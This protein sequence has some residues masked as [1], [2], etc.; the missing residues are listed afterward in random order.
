M[1]AKILILV[2]QH[3]ARN[4]LIAATHFRR[5][6]R[7]FLQPMAV[8]ASGLERKA[9]EIVGLNL[10]P[11]NYLDDAEIKALRAAFGPKLALCAW[12]L[13]RV[14][15]L[16][17]T[18]N[19]CALAYALQNNHVDFV[20]TTGVQAVLETIWRGQHRANVEYNVEQAK[21]THT[22]QS[23][24][25]YT[26]QSAI[27]PFIT[28]KP[29]WRFY[30]ELFVEAFNAALFTA[31]AFGSIP[32][33]YPWFWVKWVS[34]VCRMIEDV[35]NEKWAYAKDS[36]GRLDAAT[37][38]CECATLVAYR[39]R[40]TEA[41]TFKILAAALIIMLYSQILFYMLGIQRIG[42][43]IKSIQAILEEVIWFLVVAGVLVRAFAIMVTCSS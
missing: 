9:S 20:A 32:T 37:I 11:R 18:T 39:W 14:D 23:L 33:A 19:Y 16:N 5:L 1:L 31:F 27:L 13:L 12:E 17:I 36:W 29:A 35:L 2:A 4:A 25:N 34:R 21:R 26:D 22:A 43:Q 40:K 24:R 8:L 7:F 42:V 15:V 41:H 10:Q 3:P 6:E 28:S 30:F 38:V